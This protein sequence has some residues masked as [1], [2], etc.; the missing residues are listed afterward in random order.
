MI[1]GGFA[2]NRADRKPAVSELWPRS[3][4]K[5]DGGAPDAFEVYASGSTN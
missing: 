2:Q 5:A 4:G 3:H 1:A